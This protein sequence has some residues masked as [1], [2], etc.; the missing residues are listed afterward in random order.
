M[1]SGPHLGKLATSAVLSG[2]SQ[3]LR[4][5]ESFFLRKWC[6]FTPKFSF[7]FFW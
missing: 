6:F 5:A 1:S 7:L 4:A 3:P 2:G